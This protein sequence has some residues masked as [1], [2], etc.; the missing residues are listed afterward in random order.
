MS[1]EE[2]FANLSVDDSATLVEKVK[3]VHKKYSVS[4]EAPANLFL[5]EHLHLRGF[6]LIGY[7]LDDLEYEFVL[8]NLASE[9]VSTVIR[10]NRL[11]NFYTLINLED[12]LAVDMDISPK[13]H[14]IFDNKPVESMD[15]DKIPG[16]TKDPVG[17]DESFED[18]DVI[19]FKPE[20]QPLQQQKII[21][22]PPGFAPITTINPFLLQPEDDIPANPEDPMNVVGMLFGGSI[23]PFI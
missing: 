13:E 1:L 12:S 10:L 15:V 22:P 8:K 6:G 19:V 2:A 5:K 14:D 16:E 11:K 3:S 18:D 20:Q 21:P 17:D 4:S 9:E 23:N 7:N